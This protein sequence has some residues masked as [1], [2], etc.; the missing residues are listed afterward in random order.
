MVKKWL[1]LWSS[2]IRFMLVIELPCSDLE[3]EW[4]DI[5]SSQFKQKTRSSNLVF[6]QIAIFQALAR[7]WFRFRFRVGPI[8]VLLLMSLLFGK[9]DLYFV[10]VMKSVG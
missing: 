5:E 10:G 1:Y 4:T 8:V 3:I 2:S 9:V 7:F 6:L